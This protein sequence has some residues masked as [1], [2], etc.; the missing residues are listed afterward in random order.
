[1][2][3]IRNIFGGRA[4]ADAEHRAAPG[5]FL[6]QHVGL[7]STGGPT[8]SGISVSEQNALTATAVFACV[9]IIAEAVSTL[10]VH[11]ISRS[12]GTK[13][14]D[15]AVYRLLHDQPNEFMTAAGFRECFMANLLL[16][17]NA[18]AF[19]EKDEQ[20]RPTG[21]YPLRSSHTT[22]IR[23]GGQLVYQTTVTGQA[24]YLPPDRV[25]HVAGFSLDGITG[26]SPIQQAKQSIGLSLATE[27][28]AAKFFSNGG[29]LGGVIETPP[30]KDDALKA[31]VASWKKSYTG[32]ENS[33]KTAV[34]PGMKYH[35]TGV[36]PESAQMIDTRVHQVREIARIYRVPL[37]ML[38]DLEKASYASIEQQAMDFYSGAVQPWIVKIEQEANRKLLL[39]RERPLIETKFNMDAMLRASTQERYAAYST[40]RQGGWLSVNDIRRKE[41]LPPVPGGD[42]LL[43]P[44]N[45]QPVG[46]RHEQ[47]EQPAPDTL[48]VSLTATLDL[49]EDVAARL[50]QKEARAVERAAHKH[51]GDPDALKQWADDFYAGHRELAARHI[52]PVLK[53][54]GTRI[55]PEQWAHTYCDEAAAE[56][57]QAVDKAAEVA[58]TI[59]AIE[60]KPRHVA[61]AIL[62]EAARPEGGPQAERRDD[63]AN[64][65]D[66]AARG[67]ADHRAAA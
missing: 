35:R 29:N 16:W 10:P 49:I 55:D 48:K 28:F 54:T 53:L 23:S 58:G 20:G 12:D 67:A 6:G 57:R 43:E 25:L 21:L 2:R 7:F 19:I 22:P 14:Y 63:H 66:T 64:G 1:M 37:H 65:Q 31:F 18:Y 26:L 61:E 30:M 15:H 24:E 33:L 56:L 45:M 62:A 3:L 5:D 40:G 47:R 39:E 41:N 34:L 4:A 51:A 8:D 27:K 59:E 38:G 9:K 52:T 11:T 17:G 46:T 44:L 32:L 50:A 13:L 42:D 36:E 60:Q